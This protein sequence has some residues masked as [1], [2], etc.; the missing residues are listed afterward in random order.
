MTT[1]SPLFPLRARKS[2][3]DVFPLKQIDV[4]YNV[5]EAIAS[6]ATRVEQ[7]QYHHIVSQAITS[8]YISLKLEE[9]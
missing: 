7:V 4:L 3:V 2:T 8:H 5:S 1:K 6:G 9:Q